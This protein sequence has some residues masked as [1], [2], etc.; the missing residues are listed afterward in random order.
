M[1]SITS[2]AVICHADEPCSVNAAYEPESYF[3]MSPRSTTQP[4]Y[5]GYFGPNSAF[6]EMTDVHQ[7]GN[8]GLF[9]ARF[10]L[11]E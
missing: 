10:L 4:L 6:F 3:S 11:R 2:A 7:R 5:S 1:T 8:K 9:L